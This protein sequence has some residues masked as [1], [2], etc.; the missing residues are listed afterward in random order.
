MKILM[1]EVQRNH[2]LAKEVPYL[3][4]ISNRGK[5]VTRKRWRRGREEGKGNNNLIEAS[6]EHLGRLK[7]K[8]TSLVHHISPP[9]AIFP[10]HYQALSF[11]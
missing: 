10:L 3:L 6:G 2:S 1:A 4:C 9:T 7:K 5:R 8:D 11:V